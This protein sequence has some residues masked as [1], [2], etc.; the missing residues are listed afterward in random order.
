MFKLLKILSLKIFPL[1]NIKIKFYLNKPQK[2][3]F[4]FSET[5]SAWIY[6]LRAKSIQNYPKEIEITRIN[7]KPFRVAPTRARYVINER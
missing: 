2:A 6:L 3:N 7:E 1:L 4:C 5:I